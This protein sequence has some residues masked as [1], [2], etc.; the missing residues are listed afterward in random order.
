MSRLA[1]SAKLLRA[2]NSSATLAHLLQA[3]QLTRAELRERTGLSKPTS[4][5]MLRLLTDAGLA[6]VTGRT[7]GSVGP[8]AE[9]YAPNGDAAYAVAISVRDTLGHDRPGLATAICDLSASL[10]HRAESRVDFARVDP[11]TVVAQAVA[12][13]CERAGAEPR[14]VRHVQV[15][16]A[17]SYDPRTDVLHHVDVPGWARPGILAEIRAGL[18]L[19]AGATVAIENDVKLAA[20]AERHRGVAAGADSFSLLWLGTGVGLATDLGGVLL[21]GS[22]G[23]AGEIGYLPLCGGHAPDWIGGPGDL[24]DLVGGDAVLAL[25]AESGI[26]AATPGEAVG[27]AVAGNVDRFLDPLAHRIAFALATVVAV[28]DP[29]LVVL[30]G[31]VAQ[32]GGARL[33]DAVAAA[34]PSTLTAPAAT[35]AE[36]RN[37][38]S[39]ASPPEQRTAKTAA[40]LAE[41]RNAE[42]SGRIDYDVQIAVTAVGDDAVLLGG[43]DAGLAALHESLISSLAQPSSD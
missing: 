24:Q 19:A 14:R 4:S 13:A 29:P 22:R 36:P 38:K 35:L 27:A 41:P 34:L 6:V 32:A 9:I 40:T 3:G 8:T 16:V 11:S 18:D 5:E 2:M 26:S 31:E 1:G 42:T 17:G 12:E 25:A 10:R 15:G 33:R 37:A 20:I 7:T 43:L 30:A 28:L 21:R 39:A 23:G